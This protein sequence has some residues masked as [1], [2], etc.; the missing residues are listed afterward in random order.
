MPPPSHHPRL[1]GPSSDP[2]P[3]SQPAAALGERGEVA[4]VDADPPPA[5]AVPQTHGHPHGGQGLGQAHLGRAE[6]SDASTSC[7]LQ[8]H[9]GGVASLLR[10]FGGL[11]GRVLGVWLKAWGG[12]RA[13]TRVEG[14]VHLRGLGWTGHIGTDE[15]APTGPLCR[16]LV[17]GETVL[18]AV[19]Y[20]IVG[21]E[22]TGVR[23][24]NAGEVL[25]S[26]E[27]PPWGE[28]AR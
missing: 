24:G 18:W 1:Q 13:G 19:R 21:Q 20:V 12:G 8:V 28:T 3:P 17:L 5:L 11:E 25:P 10:T 16:V 27:A 6:G 2:P 4:A 7:D 22:L 9:R 26:M 14:G 23:P 15:L